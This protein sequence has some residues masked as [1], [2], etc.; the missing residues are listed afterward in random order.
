MAVDE[1]KIVREAL[2]EWQAEC[3]A[4]LL[5]FAEVYPEVFRRGVGALLEEPVQ[6][7]ARTKARTLLEQLAQRDPAAFDAALEQQIA[8]TS[9]QEVV[10][11]LASGRP[12][13]RQRGY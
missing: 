6:G 12:A 5:D 11:L 9:F 13:R 1:G 10:Q 3:R 2:A 8:A 4:I 7:R